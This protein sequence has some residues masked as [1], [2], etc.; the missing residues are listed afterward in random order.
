MRTLVVISLSFIYLLGIFR[1]VAPY[2]GFVA[3]Q[4]VIASKFCENVERPEMKCN[5]ACYLNKQVKALTGQSDDQAPAVPQ[6]AQQSVES[7][8][9]YA[10]EQPNLPESK[11]AFTQFYLSNDAIRR[12]LKLDSEFH[13]PESLI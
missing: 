3:N 11:R 12:S 5:G 13:P 8:Q 4:S 9:H 6:G 2:A 10:E 7:L 1:V